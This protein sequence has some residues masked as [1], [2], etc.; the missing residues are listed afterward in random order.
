MITVVSFGYGHGTPPEAD[1]TLDTR[2]LLR[3]PSADPRMR[4]LTG[5]D[6]P[7]RL[8]VLDTPGAVRLVEDTADLV[9]D[10]HHLTG[11]PVTVAIGCV[12]GRHRSVAL[13]EEL[14]GVLRRDGVKTEVEHRDVH[15]PV[16]QH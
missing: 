12:G 4:E 2:R 13:A 10:L 16:I 14:A 8:H 11:G 6:D 15:R 5:L 1:V 7:V 3:N 9:S